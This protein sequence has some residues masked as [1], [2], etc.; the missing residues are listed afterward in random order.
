MSFGVLIYPGAEELDFQGPWEIIGMWHKYSQGPKPLLVA[1]SLAP[2]TCAHGMRVLP[3]A[4]FSTCP[5]L[6]QLLVAGG[7]A[8]LGGDCVAAC[9]KNLCE[10]GRAQTRL[11]GAL[12]R[13][14]PGAT[15]ANDNHV[16]RMIDEGVC[17]R[18]GHGIL[19]HGSY[20]LKPIFNTA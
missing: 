18:C 20:E 6:T 16:E 8:A 4:D 15:C 17:A 2:V 12:R 19:M 7:Y 5:P 3:D 14:Q 11:D 1:Q 10:A 13:P 9:R